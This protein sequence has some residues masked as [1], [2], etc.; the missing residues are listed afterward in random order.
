MGV[1]DA[2]SSSALAGIKASCPG[3]ELTAD[4]LREKL[5]DRLYGAEVARRVF[6]RRPG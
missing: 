1:R 4:E 2:R 6:A 3:R 5:A